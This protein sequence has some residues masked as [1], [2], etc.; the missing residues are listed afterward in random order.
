MITSPSNGMSVYLTAEGYFTDYQSG[1]WSPR[2]AGA[3]TP[4]ATTTIAGKVQ[5]PTTVQLQSGTA[6]G[7][8]GATLS[9]SPAQLLGYYPKGDGSDGAV[10]I[11]TNTSLTRDMFYTDL[12]V[13]TGITLDPAG[14]AIFVNGTLTLT[15]TAKIARNGNAG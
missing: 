6:T 11:S 5:L 3:V 1:V 8:T 14:Y 7:G 12:T 13:N 9:L 4:N 15:G 2:S 10:V